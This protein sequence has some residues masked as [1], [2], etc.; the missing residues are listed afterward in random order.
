MEVRE[1]ENAALDGRVENLEQGEVSLKDGISVLQVRVDDV[2]H[3]CKGLK[4]QMQA[5]AAQLDDGEGKHAATKGELV[6]IQRA[7]DGEFVR[8]QD[9]STH[10][11]THARMQT[12]FSRQGVRGAEG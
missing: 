2:S 7:L 10:A 12:I 4:E 11:R 3:Q 5:A 8:R 6:K 9:G 1:N